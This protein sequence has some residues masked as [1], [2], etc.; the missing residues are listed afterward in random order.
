MATSRA[1]RPEHVNATRALGVPC[2]IPSEACV[3]FAVGLRGSLTAVKL[4]HLCDMLAP[5]TA[6]S[7]ETLHLAIAMLIPSLLPP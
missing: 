7:P 1:Q 2:A 3:V 5:P 4:S 6:G